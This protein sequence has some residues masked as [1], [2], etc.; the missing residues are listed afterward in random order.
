[1]IATTARKES[2]I[3]TST[4]TR[5]DTPVQPTR[6]EPITPASALAKLNASGYESES[7]DE[8]GPDWNSPQSVAL[9]PYSHQVGGHSA[10]FRFSRHAVCKPLVEKENAFYQDIEINRPEC[11]HSP[12]LSVGRC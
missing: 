10:L 9:K 3:S 5:D 1:M 7:G 8:L 6:K 2:A 12:I 11:I 4:A